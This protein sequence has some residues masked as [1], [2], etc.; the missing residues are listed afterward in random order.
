[1]EFRERR[2]HM[3][4]AKI[5]S[6]GQITIPIDIRKKLGLKDGDKVL[7]IEDGDKIV[8][9]NST[10]LALREAQEAFIGEAERT[11]LKNEQDVVDMIKQ[12]RKEAS[13]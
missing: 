7:F 13:L 5:T 8:M 9:V 11:G 4:L 6:K 2:L 12:L 1:M 3:E 10:I